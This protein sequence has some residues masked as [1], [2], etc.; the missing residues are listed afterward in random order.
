MGCRVG[1]STNPEQRKKDWENEYEGF[2]DW[3]ILAGP[4]SRD[5]AQKKEDEIAKER[6]CEAHHGG[7]EPDVNTGWFVYYFR[8]DIKKRAK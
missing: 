3:Q 8:S 1:I 4:L 5:E 6:G 7:D 2:S